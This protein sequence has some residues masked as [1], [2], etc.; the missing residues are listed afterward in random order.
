MV[1]LSQAVDSPLVTVSGSGG[2]P[3]PITTLD[4]AS[5]ERSH[6]WPQVLPD[7]D[8]VLFTV[9][10]LNSSESY[11]ESPI[12]A[13][14]ISTGERKTVLEGASHAK[15]IDSGHLVFARGGFL[16]AVP[17]D[18]DALEVSGTPVPVMENVMGSRNSGLSYM[19]VSGNG[20]LA[21]VPGEETYVRRVLAWGYPDGTI[22]RL[23]T[24]PVAYNAPRLARDGRRVAVTVLGDSSADTWIYDI[25]RETMTRLTFEGNNFVP[26]WSPDGAW[27]AFSSD[28][29][30]RQAIYRKPS[31]GSGAAELLLGDDDTSYTPNSW[32]PD[33]RYLA[34]DATSGTSD[35]SIL[36]IEDGEVSEFLHTDYEE[37]MSAFSPDGKW[38][39]YCANESGRYEIYVRP[40]PG[41]GGKWQISSNGGAEPYWSRDGSKLF[42]RDDERILEVDVETSGGSLRAGRP[43]VV[44]EDMEQLTIEQTYSVDSIGERF[45]E[46]VP[47]DEGESGPDR[48]VVMVNW[49]DELRRRSLAK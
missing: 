9:G 48:V 27:I 47:A 31:D 43:R 7:G 12:D 23:A 15:Y 5:N 3:R 24:P 37:Y 46:I 25:E 45:L 21:F 40:F 29:S 26:I 20:L 6:R 38:I 32:S 44:L 14:R 22:E 1:V 41:P 2:T 18:P 33:G 39:A 34:V 4:E 35:I 10:F 13:V 49:F 36:S 30:G 8:T 16:F 17:F 28:R 11:E 42:F 19:D